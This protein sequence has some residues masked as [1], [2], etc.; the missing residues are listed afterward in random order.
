MP[1]LWRINGLG[2][3]RDDKEVIR[4]WNDAQKMKKQIEREET[5]LADE[6]EFITGKWNKAE[7]PEAIKEFLPKVPIIPLSDEESDDEIIEL[8]NVSDK[9]CEETQEIISSD[10][11][12]ISISPGRDSFTCDEKMEAISGE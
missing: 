7:T 1:V 2:A 11:E 4:I 10:D 12:D 3:V 9:I 6:M 8:S 5:E